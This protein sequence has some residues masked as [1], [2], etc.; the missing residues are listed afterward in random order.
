MLVKVP[1]GTLALIYICMP[2]HIWKT[3]PKVIACSITILVF[4]IIYV[5]WASHFQLIYV[6]KNVDYYAQLNYFIHHI[7]AVLFNCLVNSLEFVSVA[8]LFKYYYMFIYVGII[9][10]GIIIAFQQ[11]TTTYATMSIVAA[12]LV[13][14]ATYLF[15][16]LTCNDYQGLSPRFLEGFQERYLLPLMPLLLVMCQESRKRP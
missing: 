7:L 9:V 12:I 15:L 3:K 11:K 13:I 6:F 5:T 1:Y 14:V 10:F 4:L 8:M 16:F 2:K